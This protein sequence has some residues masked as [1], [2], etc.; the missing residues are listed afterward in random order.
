M[1]LRA[2]LSLLLV[3]TLPACAVGGP[4]AL[5][6]ASAETGLEGP[7]EALP[8][9]AKMDGVE[10]L[11]PTVAAGAS[12]EVWSVRNQ[13]DERDTTDARRAGVSW[14]ANSGLDWEQKF[15][16]WVGAFEVVARAGYGQTVRIPTP[17]GARAFD[18][19][20]LECAEVGL[21]LRTAFASWYGLPFFVSGWDSAGRQTLF[22]GHFGFVNKRGERIANFPKFRAQ[23]TDA[24][25][26]WREG[27]AWPSD[28]RLR[29]MH[30][31][32]DDTVGFLSTGGQTLGA[33]A[34]F[35]ELFLN[36]RVGYFARLLL[37]YFGSVNLVDSANTFS[38]QP[39]ALAPGDLLIERWQKVGIG[40]VIPV[41][42]R[43]D[44]PGGQFEVAVASGSM[45]RRQPLWTETAQARSYFESQYCGGPELNAD[46]VPYAKLGGGLRRWRT[47]ALSAGR[48]RNLVRTADRAAFIDD[49]ST[50]VLAARPAR[51]RELLGT[52]TPEQKRD[53]ALA[54]I[55]TARLHLRDYPSSCSAREQREDAFVELYEVMEGYFGET[56]AEVD[57]AHR[58]LEDRVFAELDYTRSRTCCWNSSTA[59]MRELVLAYAEK[60]QR[61]AAAGSRCVE[62]TVFR[63]ESADRATGGD[64]YARWR[65]YAA[66]VGRAA[67]WRAWSEDETCAQREVSEDTVTARTGAALCSLPPSPTTT[68]CE[69]SVANDSTSAATLLGPTPLDARIC[70]GDQDFYRV[71][72][73]AATVTVSIRFTASS[74]DLDAQ[75]LTATGSVLATSAGTTGEE[76]VSGTGT[77]YVRV[78]PYGSAVNTYSIRRL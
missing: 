32:A 41:F 38:V 27:Q 23:Y 24:T 42:R 35:D 45:P 53:A 20:T 40:H 10:S 15:D 74:G 13:W 17:Y 30:L 61:D 69:P 37:L 34:Y 46:G 68:A 56:R 65:A 75:A 2:A 8:E 55:Q 72:A 60:E 7:L 77:F 19:P 78:Y 25:S 4:S 67:D 14:G 59:A 47:P 16:R 31:G 58:T 12:T 63:A 50:D 29:A 36:K 76:R 11:G 43:V 48:W 54:R 3:M 52:Q 26:S 57:A 71:D 70:S 21:F 6:E 5:D 64:G 28:A 66:S 1:K 73:G 22:A 18:A 44:L 51:F 49:S 33:G 39:E 9:A 62:P